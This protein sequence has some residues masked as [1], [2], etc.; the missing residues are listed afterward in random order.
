MHSLKINGTS[1]QVDVEDDMPLLWVLRDELGKTG[2]KYGC[3]IGQCGA[4][5]VLV[6]GEAVRSCSF[7]VVAAEDKEITTIEGL[8]NN[9]PVQQAWIEE[10]VPQCG[11]CQTGQIMATTALLSKDLDPSEKEIED[12]ITNLCRCGTYVRINKAIQRSAELIENQKG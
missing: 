5:T 11:Y 9:H 7:P 4:C 10:Q 8:G 12:K 2:T 1:H 6:N 3:G